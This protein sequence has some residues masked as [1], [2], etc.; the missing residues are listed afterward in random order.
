MVFLLIVPLYLLI[1]MPVKETL[2]ALLLMA[3]SSLVPRRKTLLKQNAIAKNLL[4]LPVKVILLSAALQQVHLI[5]ALIRQGNVQTNQK[6]NV[7]QNIVIL[8]TLALQNLLRVAQL[9]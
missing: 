6:A 8:F 3:L 4:K 2:N 5:L 1:K 9:F 7:I